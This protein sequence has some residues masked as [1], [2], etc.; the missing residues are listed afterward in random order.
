[1][2]RGEDPDH[3]QV[4]IGGWGGLGVGEMWVSDSDYLDDP[5]YAGAP[6]GTRD[7]KVLFERN[8][9]A[10]AEVMRLLKAN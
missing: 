6:L 7:D 3:A 4:L 2:G 5:D 8:L 1:M 10:E 9:V